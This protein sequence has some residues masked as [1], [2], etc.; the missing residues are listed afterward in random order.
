MVAFLWFSGV[1]QGL[2]GC[3][4]VRHSHRK[5]ALLEGDTSQSQ[6]RWVGMAGKAQFL[7]GQWEYWGTH[8]G[9]PVQK[10]TERH[11][12]MFNSPSGR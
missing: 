6:Q 10:H 5:A 8:E 1:R 9:S 12:D 2:V 4:D 11:L 7:E 3:R